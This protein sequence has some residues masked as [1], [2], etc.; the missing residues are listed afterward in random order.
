MDLQQAK[1]GETYNLYKDNS[2]QVDVFPKLDVIPA[3][4]FAV[5]DRMVLFGW[6]VNEVPP[7]NAFLRDSEIGS[8]YQY[9]DNQKDYRSYLIFRREWSVHSLV[10]TTG[11][12]VPDFL[13]CQKCF[14]FVQYAQP[15]QE[16]G[17]F[18]C[19]SCRQRHY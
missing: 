19:Y 2:G 12:N 9:L 14:D 17:T 16:D 7:V 15:N 4:I 10:S 6:K 3:T 5:S 1:L 18:V 13:P 8:D 11:T